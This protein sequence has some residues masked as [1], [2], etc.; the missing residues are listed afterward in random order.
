MTSH[1][2]YDQPTKVE[3][4]DG[5][6]TLNGPDGI[7]ISM[8]PTAAAI[9]GGRLNKAAVEAAALSG[10]KSMEEDDEDDEDDAD[11]AAPLTRQVDGG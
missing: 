2:A 5:E 8:T 7:G 11:S 4:V 10:L 9:T 6:V 1:K 3:A